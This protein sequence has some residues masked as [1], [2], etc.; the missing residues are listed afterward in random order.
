[1]KPGG[2]QPR[3]AGVGKPTTGGKGKGFLGGGP[4]GGF[5]T[6]PQQLTSKKAFKGFKS[7]K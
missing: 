7:G 3:N 1:M 5:V 4:N 2:G 6:T